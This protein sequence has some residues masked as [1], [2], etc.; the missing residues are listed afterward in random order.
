MRFMGVSVL[1]AALTVVGIGITPHGPREQSVD[2]DQAAVPVAQVALSGPLRITTSTRIAPGTYRVSVPKGTAA[3]EIDADSVTLDLSGVTLI[4]SADDASH[5]EVGPDPAGAVDH[6]EYG[7]P[8]EREGT[9]VHAEGHSHLTIRGGAIHGYRFGIFVQGGDDIT[10]SGVDVGGN[11]AQRLL[12]TSTHRDDRDWADIFHLDAW[13]SY[14]AGLY[15]KDVQAAWIENVQAHDAQ[16]GVMLANVTHAT[17]TR[18]DLS[19]NSGWGIALFRSS[20]NDLLD[21]R[22]DWDVRCEG[23][24]YSAGCD[25]AGVLLMDG[26]NSNR[27]IGNSFTHSGDG[28]FLSYPETGA[29]SNDNIVAFNDGS[30]SPHNAFESTFT[31]GDQFYHN[32]ADHCDYGF[33]LGFSRDTTVIDNHIEGSKRDGIAIEHGSGNILSRNQIL[34]NGSAGIRLFRS[35]PRSEP[36]AHYAILQN[37]IAGNK[38]GIFLGQTDDVT[39]SGNEFTG[40]EVGVRIEKTSAHIVLHANHFSPAGTPTVQ[41]DD[42]KSLERY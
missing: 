8:W 19:R 20:G 38:V 33:W 40:N 24:T 25:S 17:V 32:I 10:V 18:N 28:Y 42:P 15:L 21:N 6:G 12:S 9:G 41:A 35:Q 16:N 23:T 29:T 39:I 30:Y 11:R 22:A 14:G 31:S 2:S 13:E 37:P 7:R 27:V 36:S 1:A 4:G 3:I 34:R 5:D 26:S